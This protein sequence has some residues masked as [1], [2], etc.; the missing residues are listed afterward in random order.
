MTGGRLLVALSGLL[1]LDLAA[2]SAAFLNT[3]CVK[4]AAAL[5]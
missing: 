3:T 1:V 2:L 5:L 4:G